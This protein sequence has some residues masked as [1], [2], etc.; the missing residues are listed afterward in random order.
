MIDPREKV[1][2]M[3]TLYIDSLSNCYVEERM[4]VRGEKRPLHACGRVP[5]SVHA[6]HSSV[7]LVSPCS[8]IS[9]Q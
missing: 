6:I 8:K 4:P 3:L 1:A 7:F 9:S 5:T 2:N